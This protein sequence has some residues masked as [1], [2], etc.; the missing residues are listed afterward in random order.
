MEA[1][2][3]E[4]RNDDMR[5]YDVIGELEIS[6]ELAN[7]GTIFA[8]RLRGD[9]M[10]PRINDGDIVVVR[11]Q[12][13]VDSGSLCIVAVNGDAA[14]CKILKKHHDGIELIPYNPSHATRFFHV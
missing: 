14:T 5:S 3:A 8:L 4:E 13:D 2:Q 1:C 6:D 7:S 10:T 9:S 11:Q 12:S